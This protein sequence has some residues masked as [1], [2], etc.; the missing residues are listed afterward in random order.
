[1]EKYDKLSTILIMLKQERG[2]RETEGGGSLEGPVTKDCSEGRDND[3]EQGAKS[4]QPKTP[5]LRK[6]SNENL[7]TFNT[8]LL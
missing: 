7:C 5:V 8:R 2:N 1:M 6:V 3:N 4:V